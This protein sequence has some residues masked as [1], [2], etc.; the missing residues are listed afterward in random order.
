MAGFLD[1][2]KDLAKGL[3][4][5]AKTAVEENAD[6]IEGGIDKA[7]DFV[8]DKTKGKYT[9]KI[10]K[11]QDAAHRAV[12]KIGGDQGGSQEKGS[13]D[14]PDETPGETPDA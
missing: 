3:T 4:G 9:D 7:A 13:S 8:D 6:K 1:K 2:A 11:A 14:P 10:E 12:E 5:K